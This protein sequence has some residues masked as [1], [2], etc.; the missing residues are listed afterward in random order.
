[1]S[2][3][4]IVVRVLDGWKRGIDEHRPA[5]VAT[6]FAHD[7]LFQGSHPDYSLGRGGV[8]EYYREQPTG[9]TVR[10]TIRE[11]RSLADGVLSVYLDPDFTRPDGAVWRFHLTVILA[12]QDNGD[13][14]INHYHVSR[15]D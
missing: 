7:A 4:D 9:L 5:D 11:I 8:A 3:R 2:Y 6:L 1:V 12:R 10:Y 13:W 15:I 14:L